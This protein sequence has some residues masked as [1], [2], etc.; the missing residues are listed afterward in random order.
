MG[1]RVLLNTE[2]TFLFIFTRGHQ[3]L[4]VLWVFGGWATDG[5]DRNSSRIVTSWHSWTLLRARQWARYSSHTLPLLVLRTLEG[6]ILVLIS[7]KLEIRKRTCPRS[8]L[9][10]HEARGAPCE[11]KVQERIFIFMQK[12]TIPIVSASL[13]YIW[14]FFLSVTEDIWRYVQI[15]LCLTSFSMKM[16]VSL[17]RWTLRR[18]HN[19]SP[20]CLRVCYEQRSYEFYISVRRKPM[21]KRWLITGFLEC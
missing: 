20:S 11:L 18:P 14:P 5:Y 13:A 1:L 9:T 12:D 2:L 16:F 7:V 6:A 3:A 8:Q 21:L 19:P 4:P 10:R 17:A 15:E